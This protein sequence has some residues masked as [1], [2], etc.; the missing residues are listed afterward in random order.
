MKETVSLIYCP[1]VNITSLLCPLT[2]F[3][4]AS[5]Y[6]VNLFFV[7]NKLDVVVVVVRIRHLLYWP[8]VNEMDN[9]SGQSLEMA[10]WIYLNEDLEVSFW[11][12]SYLDAM[13]TNQKTMMLASYYISKGVSLHL[14]RY[15]P[16]LR[17]YGLVIF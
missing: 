2:F 10:E 13:N 17:K 15:L 14:K 7:I 1:K 3:V 6:I 12:Y 5:I 9:K 8:C 16:L 4:T 11:K